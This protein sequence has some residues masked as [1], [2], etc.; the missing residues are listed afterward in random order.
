MTHLSLQEMSV[1]LGAALLA[2]LVLGFERERR[3]RAA[4]LRTTMLVCVSSAVAMLLSQE[5]F[6]DADP[7]AGVSAWHPDPARLAAG[8]LTGMGFL[9]GGVIL[10]QNDH[11]HGVTTAAVLWFSSILGL[12]VGAGYLA[13]GAA[14]FGVVLLTLVLL[15]RIESR[16]AADR[17]GSLTLLVTDKGPDTEKV[18]T[19]VESLGL[20]AKLKTSGLE[21]DVQ[22]GQRTMRFEVSV[23]RLRYAD[24]ASI[25]VDR[26]SE[27]DGVKAVR[28]GGST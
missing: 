2:G 20:G 19:V 1:R 23:K 13:L 16:L 14:G 25:A 8:V 4:G 26:L 6:V 10:R 3:G 11:I 12:A 15:P 17:Y 9:G 21:K 22:A 28:W 18:R 7:A 5:L 27:L 24:F